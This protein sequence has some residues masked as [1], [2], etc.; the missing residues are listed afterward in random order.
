AM[1][2]KSHSQQQKLQQQRN[3]T[4]LNRNNNSAATAAKSEASSTSA[5]ASKSA[6]KTVPVSSASTAALAGTDSAVTNGSSEAGVVNSNSFD[7][8][9]QA[10][11]E[12]G[13]N[14]RNL[15]KFNVPVEDAS[16]ASTASKQS[17][18]RPSAASTAASHQHQPGS[19]SGH[20]KKSSTPVRAPDLRERY[21]ALLL[22][23]LKRTIDEIYSTC[24]ADQSEA[25]CREVHIILEHCCRDFAALVEKIRLFSEDG[26][27]ERIGG[28]PIAWEERKTSPCKPIMKQVLERSLNAG[29]SRVRSPVT[30][31]GSVTGGG[32]LASSSNTNNNNNNSN[33]SSWADKVRASLQQQQL[34]LEAGAAVVAVANAASGSSST[35]LSSSSTSSAAAA[36][37]VANSAKNASAATVIAHPSASVAAACPASVSDGGWAVVRRGRRGGGGSSGKTTSV[38]VEA[39]PTTP[40]ADTGSP[41]DVA[42]SADVDA[43]SDATAVPEK[44]DIVEP[45]LGDV[46][47]GET[48]T[49]KSN[50]ET[51]LLAEGPTSS[52][53]T[54]EEFDSDDLADAGTGSEVDDESTGDIEQL[55]RQLDAMERDQAELETALNHEELVN[56]VDYTRPMTWDE[57]VAQNTRLQQTTVPWEL[58]AALQEEED[59][60]EE[61]FGERARTP[62]RCAHIH[63]KLSARKRGDADADKLAE[64][65]VKARETRERLF[66]ERVE[67]VRDLTKRIDEVK[68]ERQQ[69]LDERRCLLEQRMSRA[70][71]KRNAALEEKIRKAHDEETKGR[72]IQFIQSLGAEQRLADIAAKHAESEQRL[73]EKEKV[74]R[75]RSEINAKRE[76]AAEIRR[77]NIEDSRLARL[78][79]Q[80]ERRACKER[81]IAEKREAAAAERARNRTERE[82]K[83]QQ[84]H[85]QLEEE[86]ARSINQLKDR[87]ER[88][89][90][91]TQRRHAEQLREISR[92]AFDL[93]IL[94]HS[95][96]R[97]E[98]PSAPPARPYPRAQ[99]C[100][101]CRTL[102]RSEVELKAHL[103]SRAHL[104]CLGGSDQDADAYN[105][106]HIIEAPILTDQSVKI[107]AG[108]AGGGSG[109]GADSSTV[110]DSILME[111]RERAKSMRKKA[112]RLRQKFSA[113]SREFQQQL[114]QQQKSSNSQPKWLREIRRLLTLSAGPTVGASS[115]SNSNSA[116]WVPSRA[117]ALDRALN[118]GLRSASQQLKQ[119]QQTQT[120]STSASLSWS[121]IEG[122]GTLAQLLEQRLPDRSLALCQQ[123]LCAQLARSPQCAKYLLMSGR[124][125]ALLDLLGKLPDNLVPVLTQLFH[126]LPRANLTEKPTVSGLGPQDLLAYLLCSG[127]MDSLAGLLQAASGAK[128]QSPQQLS[129][130]LGMM[131][132]LLE[133][134]LHDTELLTQLTQALIPLL[135][136]LLLQPPV[137]SSPD[138]GLVGPA[139]RLLRSL[140][141]AGGRHLVAN[142]C[143]SDDVLCLELRHIAASVLRSPEACPQP[144]SLLH[145]L[146]DCLATVASLGGPDGQACAQSGPS[147]TVL[148]LLA[149]LPF[150]YFSEPSLRRLLFPA[151]IACTLHN[152]P[153]LNILAEDLSPRMIVAFLD[154]IA[155]ASGADD[156]Q[157]MT[158]DES[159][160]VLQLTVPQSQIGEIRQFYSDFLCAPAAAGATASSDSGSA[161]TA[162][163]ITAGVPVLANG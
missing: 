34:L 106:A 131:R 2:F 6:S 19:S 91:D 132:A 73:A 65:Q 154:S 150:R 152:L 17:S 93:S 130:A 101:A 105:L 23:N 72:E 35:K 134:G 7:K 11:M 104:L 103:R 148:Q 47:S 89:Q 46:E 24:E 10:V 13:A 100:S 43:Q 118:E 64:K 78:A 70:E 36:A 110:V 146:L 120:A 161:G 107:G 14:A 127:A 53:R 143:L 97:D 111:A 108:A 18:R 12:E 160:R 8:L 102:I 142:C 85:S 69:L 15:L 71:A 48:R 98:S 86:H 5:A 115:N 145:P 50:N 141:L 124:A 57:L 126:Q 155:T 4:R 20:R 25:E 54:V 38:A 45:A 163:E 84:L 39:T 55:E 90:A 42:A 94:R 128:P 162:A 149:R 68:Q 66:E 92:R 80:Q 112:R 117:A 1:S 159:A 158:V 136:S 133:A 74:R 114:Q 151:V 147:P 21:W 62:G 121:E 122:S 79:S 139:I 52:S 60:D 59:A 123:L 116:S 51:T 75:R 44:V 76:A 156:G 61:T 77:K 3:R 56:L 40:T 157:Q 153:H 109:D 58:M 87:I 113:K 30:A 32:H 83:R 129:G 49:D 37:V 135:Y 28:A 82:E 119:Q 88:R 125:P 138:W 31:N 63:D 9:K 144:E 29:S 99:F 67:R 137:G 81:E 33:S 140:L 26:A 16:A 22:E 96:A 95:S 41:E 27:A